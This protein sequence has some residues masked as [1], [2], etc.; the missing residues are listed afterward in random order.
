MAY[1]VKATEDEE[2]ILIFSWAEVIW[3][4][5]HFDDLRWMFHCPNG[6]YRS[7]ATAVRLKAMGV[8]RG[9]PDIHLPVPKHGY[10]GLVIELKQEHG[11]RTSAEQREWLEHYASI[12]WKAVSH[13]GADAAIGEIE[14]YLDI[15]KGLYKMGKALL[16]PGVTIKK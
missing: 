12:G 13:H 16:I 4:V 3:Q 5:Y 1:R 6:G 8:K 10:N 14:D 15:P 9:V 7:K 2:Q 11:G